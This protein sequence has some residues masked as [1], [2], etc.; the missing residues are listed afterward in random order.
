MKKILTLALSVISLL[1]YEMVPAK[2][3]T[4]SV[5]KS[6]SG[7]IYAKNQVMVATRLMGYIKKMNVEEGDVVHKGDVLF[8]VDP[9]DIYS[10]INQAR[11]GV[12][13]AQNGLLMAK[14]AY[15]D[16]QKDYDRF[17][18]LYEK[19]AVSQRTFD[20]MKLNMQLR[21]SQIKLAQAMLDQAKAGLQRALDQKKY[22]KVVSPIDGV[23]VRKMTKIAEMAIPGHPVVILADLNSIQA[24]AFVKEGD[25]K[26]LKKGQKATVY[27]GAVNKNIPS[28]V[29]SIIPSADPATHSYLVK[30]KLSDKTDL[31][32]GMY[33]KIYVNVGNTKEVVIP[34]N[35]LTSRGGI[36][37][38]FV[39]DNNKAK[40]VAVDVVSQ[41]NNEVAVKGINSG[42]KVIILPPANLVDGMSLN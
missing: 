4:L 38:V 40:F 34:Y 28:Q 7:D 39:D 2:I 36:V 42:D 30:F 23:V 22:A 19:G 5:E 17:K 14:L 12:M 3:K 27:V 31:L 6:Y 10:M 13:Q 20:K 18:N 15:A 9:S 21:S 25:V 32:P 37:G 41:D 1:A 8:V 26:E 24:R 33:A 11:A 29:S 35:A 16:A